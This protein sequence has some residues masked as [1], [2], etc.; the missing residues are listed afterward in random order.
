MGDDAVKLNENFVQQQLQQNNVANNELKLADARTPQDLKND[1]N[2]T[3]PSRYKNKQSLLKFSSTNKP[4]NRNSVSFSE[5]LP[6]RLNFDECV[7]SEN[8]DVG[9]DVEPLNKTINPNVSL[10]FS[11]CSPQNVSA[12]NVN[13]VQPST[14]NEIIQIFNHQKQFRI[15]FIANNVPMAVNVVLNIRSDEEILYLE[16]VELSYEGKK[17]WRIS[18]HQIS[19]EIEAK[20]EADKM[21]KNLST[22]FASPAS[23]SS[24]VTAPNGP[25]P[26]IDKYL[27]PMALSSLSNLPQRTT[28]STS[29]TSNSSVKR[30]QE[31][32]GA[33]K[34]LLG[35]I[36]GIAVV[37]VVAKRNEMFLGN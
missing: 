19:K 16:P 37:E 34:Y 28:S 32:A 9:V 26:K 2:K 12:C 18:A 8:A 22:S 25:T 21:K 17:V 33:K 20:I 27:T 1:L 31:K 3:P 30:G 23:N 11:D 24:F 4:R 6:R 5:T 14:P 35:Q 15:G 7:E 36:G 29:V 10:E 13:V